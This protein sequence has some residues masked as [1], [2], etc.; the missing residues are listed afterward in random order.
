MIGVLRRT[1]VSDWHFENLCGSHLQTKMVVLV[2]WKLKKQYCFTLLF[3]G[4]AHFCLWSAQCICC[5]FNKV[6]NNLF[7]IVSRVKWRLRGSFLL[8][9]KMPPEMLCQDHFWGEL[10]LLDSGVGCDIIWHYCINI[11]YSTY[12]YQYGNFVDTVCGP[13]LNLI[14][15]LFVCLFALVWEHHSYQKPRNKI[16]VHYCIVIF[17]LTVK[18]VAYPGMC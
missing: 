17:L 8:L 12:G 3:W 5:F 13:V 2:S 1:V 9:E 6:Q 4:R 14:V 7:V 15:C 11:E 16:F 18:I 10:W